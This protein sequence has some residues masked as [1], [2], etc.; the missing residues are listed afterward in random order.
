[1]STAKKH[2]FSFLL[3]SII[4]IVQ[5]A[6]FLFLSKPTMADNALFSQQ[7]GMTE[8]RQAFGWEEQSDIRVVIVNIIRIVLG[9]LAIIFVTLIVFA[10]FRYM[11]AGGNE[12]QTKEALSNIKNAV[13]GLAIIMT[14]WLITTAVM[15]YLVRAVNNNTQIWEK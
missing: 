9:L 6:G 7:E 14:S 2:F 15:R 1:M 11:T 12:D 4:S 13:I 10:G 8:V 3:V 5:I